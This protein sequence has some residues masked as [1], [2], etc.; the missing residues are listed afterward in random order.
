M[1]RYFFNLH[2][3]GEALVDPEGC[4]LPDLHAAREYAVMEAREI[5]GAEVSQGR[6]CL[7]CHI[8]ILDDA[9]ILVYKLPFREALTLTGV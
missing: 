9:G 5:M 4:L 6:L 8:E 1:I 7:A 2:E 3:C